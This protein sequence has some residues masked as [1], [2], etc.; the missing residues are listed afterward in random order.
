MI[1]D[2]LH[3]QQGLAHQVPTALETSSRGM[4]CHARSIIPRRVVTRRQ[5]RAGLPGTERGHL[6]Q[7]VEGRRQPLVGGRVPPPRR[8]RRPRSC[9]GVSR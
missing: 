2:V 3:Q 8:R 5:R 9:V 7:R 6:A 1:A 4:M